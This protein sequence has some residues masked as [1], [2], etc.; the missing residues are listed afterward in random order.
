MAHPFLAFC[1]DGDVEGL[2]FRRFSGAGDGLLRLCSGDGLLLPLLRLALLTGLAFFLAR[3]G[4]PPSLEDVLGLLCFL[5][6]ERRD[7]GGERRDLGGERR[8][9]GGGESLD[10]EGDR[11]D[12]PG[13]DILL[14]GE[15][16]GCR[17]LDPF[18]D[19]LGDGLFF[20]GL[21]LLF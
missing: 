9:L 19:L 16:L 20:R 10:R 3:T 12:F 21:T 11:R 2:L 15:T 7:L 6:G 13:G 1:G 18:D 8:D 14:R 5:D 4:E 17:T